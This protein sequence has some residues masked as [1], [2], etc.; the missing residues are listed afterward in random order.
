MSL[1]CTQC[2]I[3]NLAENNKILRKFRHWLLVYM[4]ITCSDCIVVKASQF[5]CN[6]AAEHVID[7]H[8]C[9]VLRDALKSQLANEGVN[10]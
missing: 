6:Q 2:Y 1:G 10:T 5:Y 3:C 7:L 9:V 4:K 8:V